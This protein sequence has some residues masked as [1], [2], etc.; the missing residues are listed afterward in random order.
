VYA[1]RQTDE[2]YLLRDPR[3]NARGARVDTTGPC[4]YAAGGFETTSWRVPRHSGQRRMPR[5][6]LGIDAGGTKTV[7]LLADES[8]AVV[9]RARG[10]GANLQAQ[11]ELEV[12]K[13]LH[14]LMEAA[15][16]G[17]DEPPAAIC[18]G[19]AG[20]DRPEDATTMRGLMRRIGY[21][22]RTVIVNDAL[23]AL[24]AGA[25][26][27]PGVVV[28][29]GTGSICY[30]RD[31]RGRAARSGGW[32]FVLGDEGSGYWMGRRTLAAVVR[33]ADGR[34]PATALTPLVLEHFGIRQVSD[35]VHEVYVADPRRKRVAG[36]GEALQVAVEA[37]DPIA[38]EIVD[39]AARELV[40]AAASVAERLEMRGHV[41][42]FLLAGGIFRVVHAVREQVLR[43][44][45]EVAPRS[46]A[47]V[48]AAEPAMG[49]VHLAWAEARG[50]ARIPEYF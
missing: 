27:G 16:A 1:H 15:L 24:V 38:R 46:I 13:V 40:T 49:A 14:E 45:P 26:D 10:P 50:G 9:S 36:L 6:V 34:G 20:A 32:G 35:L 25:G 39:A 8:G 37:G 7:C 28:V 30:G 48:L 5:Y 17:R 44:L 12:E 22:S 2:V 31:D 42:P 41:F 43:L 18:L 11:G 23:V 3:V 4:P 47:Q 21:K 29:S 19:V 33:H